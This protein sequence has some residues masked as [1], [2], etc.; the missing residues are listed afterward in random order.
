MEGN[1][2]RAAVKK[3]GANILVKMLMA[4]LVP[5]I[6]LVTMAVLA[7]RSVGN[8]TAEGL[9][10]QELKAMTYFA[11]NT[12]EKASDGGYRY[13]DGCLYKG[14]LDLTEDNNFLDSFR[15]NSEV[16][17]AL[18]YGT[19]SVATSMLDGSDARVLGVEAPESV[20]SKVLNGEN[21]F[22]SGVNMGGRDYYGY[23]S[24]LYSG[25]GGAP[26]G[27]LLTA[28][29][30]DTAK[31]TYSRLLTS[32][33]IFMV[34]LV[35]LFTVSTILVVLVIVKA[36][37]AMVGNIDRMAEGELNF[38]ISEKLLNRSDEVGKIARSVHAVIVRFSE[39]L[40]NLHRTTGELDE[41]STQ[42][43]ENFDT[44]GSS[45]GNVNVAVDEIAKGATQQ[46]TDTQRVS[47]SLD[48]MSNAIDKT[49][50]G[51]ESLSVSA[52][53]MRQN[54]EAMEE[55][56]QELIKISERTQQSVDEVQTQTNLTNQ[57]AQDIRS[58]TDIIA[59]I[60]SQTNLLSLNA[61]IEAARAGEMGRG[62]AVVAEEIRQLADQSK[63]SADQIRNIVETLILNSDHS[64]DI[65]NGVVQEIH[66]QSDKLDVTHQ[67]FEDLNRE[68]RR[69]VEAVTMIASETE[70]IEQF[71]N[72]VMEG[73]E[74]LSAV[75]QENAA[76]TQETSA[77][78][79]ELGN[80]V[81]DCVRATE[82]LV[83]ISESLSEN[84]KHFKLGTE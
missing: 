27:M 81:E 52:D 6:V 75:S 54:N 42:F 59:D 1:E 77:S 4:F 3:T 58:A 46:A 45:I 73:I 57:S 49:A 10:Q 55:T 21:C 82:R 64:V 40:L 37:M 30:V 65:M 39:V 8:G 29:P 22:E 32:N 14:E 53:K 11:N 43:K 13:E 17:I 63:E 24:P 48:D 79:M 7:L 67:A 44:I 38:K 80:I 35:A 76:S 2:R 70:H 69:V 62:F 25:E 33:I 78:M 36:L 83:A 26:V 74:N 71:K 12:L 5:M 50:G 66:L 56:L 20:S 60:A 31:H 18:F 23:F 34:L 41:F 61:S 84:A 68:I 15:E 9:V 19:Q 72:G 51:I 28:L 47:E 16:E